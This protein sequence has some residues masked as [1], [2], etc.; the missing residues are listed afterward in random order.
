[1]KNSEILR[2]RIVAVFLAVLFMPLRISAGEEIGPDMLLTGQYSAPITISLYAPTYKH[3]MQFGEERTNSLNSVLSHLSLSV[4]TDRA[5]SQTTLMVDQEP[6]YSIKEQ[7]EGETQRRI[8]SFDP[9][10]VYEQE[11]DNEQ[12]DQDFLSFLEHHFFI[13]NRLLDDLYPVFEKTA[14]TFQDFAKASAASLNF[15]GYGKGVR[16]IQINLTD[17]YV[18]EYFPGVPASLAGTAESR[19]FIEKLLFKGPQKIALLY[20]QNDKLLRINYDGLIGLTE[21][22]MRRVSLAWRCVRSDDIKKDNLVLKTPSQQGNDRYNL[23]YEREIDLS[24]TERHTIKWDYQLDLKKDQQKKKN[25]WTADLMYSEQKL[26]GQF[27]FSEKQD[28]EEKK[29]TVTPSLMKEKGSEY[30]GTIEITNN[31]GKIVNSS[32]AVSV[33][34]APGLQLSFPDYQ[35]LQI[36]SIKNPEDSSDR[37]AI[38]D[39]QNRILIRR[40]LSLPAEDLQFF[41]MDIPDDV[42]KTIMQSMI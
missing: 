41:S 16:K 8:Y 24:D 2:I 22:S 11:K 38:Q 37:E 19:L 35:N 20:D 23:T 26:Y 5:V 7:I 28:N 10:T 15:R 27:L 13:L 31:S 34:I 12:H 40:L 30:A 6:L 29:I 17:Q 33:R 1:M 3:L 4:S 9:N 36:V 21:E 14:E 39:K 32:I 42:W 18:S 25:S